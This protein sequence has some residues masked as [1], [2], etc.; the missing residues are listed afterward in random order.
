MIKSISL[1]TVVWLAPSLMAGNIGAK[2]ADFRLDDTNGATH[3]LS[4]Y[5]GRTVV[6]AFWS[7][8][9]PVAL[10]AAD[11]IGA[12]G[13]KFGSRGVVVLGIAS[14]ANETA[15]EIRRNAANLKVGFPV[16]LDA[17]GLVADRFGANHTP[18]VYVVDPSGVLRYRGGLENTAPGAGRSG[19][20]EDSVE[21][22]LEGRPVAVPETPAPGCTIRRR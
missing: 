5:A 19:P 13:A 18:S 7:F 15:A 6:V 8:K 14:S 20:V 3:S 9:C 22:I 2:V 12:I 16:L 11:R 1:L 4:G 17:D 10:A 21:A